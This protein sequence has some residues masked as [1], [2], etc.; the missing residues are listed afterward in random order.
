MVLSCKLL[1]GKR[2]EDYADCRMGHQINVRL[3][4]MDLIRTICS[5]HSRSP[6]VFLGLL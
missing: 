1:V 2:L 6:T 4:R 3:G 5:T